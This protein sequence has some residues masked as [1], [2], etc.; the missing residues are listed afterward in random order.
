MYR[1]SK[2]EEDQEAGAIARPLGQWPG[3]PWAMAGPV[4]PEGGGGAEG[5]ISA[6]TS[7]AMQMSVY[8]DVLADIV[9][10]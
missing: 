7:A 9:A 3:S 6:R 4:R 8:S 5:S 1:H 2:R 10:F